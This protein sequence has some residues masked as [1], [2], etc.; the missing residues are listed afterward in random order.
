MVSG[1]TGNFS[2]GSNDF[3]S[4]LFALPSPSESW[5]ANDKVNEKLLSVYRYPAH[6]ARHVFPGF[7]KKIVW[8][9]FYRPWRAPTPPR[10]VINL[11]FPTTNVTFVRLGAYRFMYL[12]SCDPLV[13]YAFFPV[14]NNIIDQAILYRRRRI[15][16][17]CAAAPE[18]FFFC[19]PCHARNPLHLHV[20]F[21]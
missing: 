16:C 15:F 4:H 3:M 12:Y 6:S 17:C 8:C 11:L 21:N 19:R 13:P 2:P 1:R 10:A 5:Y 20:T 9:V 14:Y 18:V 7:T